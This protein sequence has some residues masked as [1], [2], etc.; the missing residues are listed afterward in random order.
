MRRKNIFFGHGHID[1]ILENKL[2]AG[3]I[4]SMEE[5]KRSKLGNYLIRYFIGSG[6]HSKQDVIV[7]EDDYNDHINYVPII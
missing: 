1:G 3:T 7:Y 5:D 2:R 6:F 4:I